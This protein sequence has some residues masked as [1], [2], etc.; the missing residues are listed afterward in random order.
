MIMKIPTRPTVQDNNAP[1]SAFPGELSKFPSQDYAG[2]EELWRQSVELWMKW[3]TAHE[4]LTAAMFACR[5]EPAQQAEVMQEMDQLDQLRWR[6]VE[7]SQ[8]LLSST[9]V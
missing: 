8:E 3:H 9:P 5:H 2:A 1:D 7:I 4:R 6:A